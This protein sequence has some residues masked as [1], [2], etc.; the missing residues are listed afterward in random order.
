MRLARPAYEGTVVDS[1]TRAPLPGVSVVWPDVRLVTDAQGKF[2]VRA[3]TYREMTW[4]GR[5]APP[6][7]F[8]FSLQKHGYC[9]RYIQYFDSRGGGGS[10]DHLW[11]HLI[12]P[13]PV[14][15]GPCPPLHGP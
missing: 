4:P 14:S 6:L 12:Q 10:A 1:A 11:R 8:S 13:M 15:N 9:E 5:E 3:R 2:A 7:H